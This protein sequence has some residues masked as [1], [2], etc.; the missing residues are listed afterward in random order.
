MIPINGLRL[1]LLIPVYNDWEAVSVLLQMLDDV[2]ERMPAVRA[3][4]VLVDDGSTVDVSDQLRAARFRNLES[5][6]ILALRRNLG[7]QRAIAIALAFLADL[8]RPDAVVIMDGDGEDAPK[9]V[10][11]LIERLIETDGKRIVFASRERRS[12]SL[13]FR[14]FY[15]FY[16]YAHLALTAIPVRVGNFSIIPFALL[17]RLVAVSELWN[18]YAAAVFKSR[19]PRDTIPTERAAR[20][21]GKPQMNFVALVSH[22]LSALSVHAEVIGVRLLVATAILVA[23]ISGLFTAVVAIRLFTQLAI[24]GWATTV[25]GLLF[26]VTMQAAVLA[27]FFVFLV[28]HGRS[29]P[30]FVP[31][32][33]YTYFVRSE[34]MLFERTHEVAAI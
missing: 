6:Q 14:V 29:Q 7:H 25:G 17:D 24:P 2:M 1:S 13:V 32:R 19:L 18:H 31:I 10:P 33:D 20:L 23:G 22:G 5:L 26:V 12:E 9:D 3:S 21:A 4:V 11:R 8:V 16:R 15:A 27:V 34:D 28:L 30:A